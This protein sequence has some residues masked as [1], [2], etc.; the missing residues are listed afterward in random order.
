MAAAVATE[1]VRVSWK[2]EADSAPAD[3]EDAR[4][5]DNQYCAP[6]MAS[7]GHWSPIDLKDGSQWGGEGDG[8]SGWQRTVEVLLKV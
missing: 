4:W 1:A 7:A 6:S 3:E 5:T 8:V 2:G